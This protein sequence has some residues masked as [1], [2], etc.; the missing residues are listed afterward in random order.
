MLALPH[1][2]ACTSPR[3]DI[4]GWHLDDSCSLYHNVYTYFFFFLWGQQGRF[5]EL[6]SSRA[7]PWLVSPWGFVISCSLY[8][9]L[10]ISLFFSVFYPINC[11][12]FP[13]LDCIKPHSCCASRRSCPTALPL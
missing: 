12:H 10:Y 1:N 5:I 8:T 9:Y 4:V 2:L 11:G 6:L 13:L 3:R 7:F